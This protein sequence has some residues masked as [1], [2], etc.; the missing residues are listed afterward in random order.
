MTAPPEPPATVA[1]L[2]AATA[3]RSPDRPFLHVTEDTA[4]TYALAAGEMSYAAAAAAVARLRAL[5]AAAGYGPGHRV[6]LMLD[7][8]PSFFLH[9]FAL[10]GLGAGVVP[11]SAAL[12]PA[13][14]QYLLGHSGLH[15]GVA[16]P[17]HCARLAAAM[18]RLPVLAPAIAEDAPP[19][20]PRVPP[21]ASEAPRRGTEAALLYTSGTTGPPKGCVLANDY[22]LRVGAWYAAREGLAA[23]RPGDRLITPLPLT[24]MNAMAYSAMAMVATAGCL[25]QLDRFH[26][27]SWWQEVRA[28]GATLMH[29]LGVMPAMLLAA[30]PDAAERDHH[31]RFGFGAGVDPRQHAAFEQRFGVPLLEAW[32]MTETGAGAVVIADRE[33]R[34]VGTGC[35]GRPAPAVEIHIEDETGAPCLPG[36]AGEL[37][38]RAAG[39]DPRAGFFTAY[40]HEPEATEAAWAGGWFH[41]GDLVRADPAGALYFVDRKKNLIR[42]SGENVSAAEVETVL[43]RHPAVADVAL[44]AAPD[45]LRGEEVLACIVPRAPVAAA[46]APA[47]ALDLVRHA[48]AELSY[49]K[50]PGWVA[51][52][53]A[54]P[55]TASQ[56]VARGEM[57][58]LAARLLAEGACH[59]TRALKRRG[60]EGA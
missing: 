40:L 45:P 44:A 23:L 38:V 56:K 58:A 10:N 27:R 59:D 34:G 33:P 28:S 20:A 22:F 6:G 50:V 19:P 9:W 49:F 7:N 18:Q 42:R 30:P 4:R 39:P 1:A 32:A 17:V 48:L 31:L 60:E 57:K 51:F 52:L 43:R 47:L 14:L 41:T 53:D 36:Q 35:F 15:L 37:L 13:E 55:L 5:Y 24:H 2:F 29:Y 26:P 21:A 46:A 8:R 11:L 16:A 25:I 3:D 12:R 54:L